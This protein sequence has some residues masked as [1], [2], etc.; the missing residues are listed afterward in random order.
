MSKLS[1]ARRRIELMGM[2]EAQ[3]ELKKQRRQLF[4]LRMQLAR[5]EVK[6][7]RQFPQIRAD[8]ARLMYHISELNR[9][10]RKELAR[11]QQAGVVEAAEAEPALPPASE[12]ATEPAARPARRARATAPKAEA[13]TETTA[14]PTAEITASADEAQ[15]ADE[16]GD[17][18]AGDT[19]A[20]EADEAEEQDSETK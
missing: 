5:G 16:A 7:N 1:E 11:A 12:A 17:T 4:D 10:A 2:A 13:A 9:E 3:E 6:N 19:E 20:G 8:I 18:E 15:A 14:E